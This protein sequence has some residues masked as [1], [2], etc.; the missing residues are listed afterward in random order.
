M[1]RIFPCLLLPG[2]LL[3][4]CGDPKAD[5]GGPPAVEREYVTI[6]EEGLGTIRFFEP[7][8]IGEDL[9][10]KCFSVP[11]T[12]LDSAAGTV[13][14]GSADPFSDPFL[15][16]TQRESGPDAQEVLEN[17]GILFGPDHFARYYPA[18]SALVVVLP[19]EQLELVEAYMCH[20][21]PGPPRPV[22]IYAEVYE[23]EE[24][25]HLH[26]LESVK[27]EADHTPE[28][29][30]LFAAAKLGECSLEEAIILTT[31]S[32]MRAKTEQTESGSKLEVDPVLSADESYLD[33]VLRYWDGNETEGVVI[34][35][36]LVAERQK[37]VS[38]SS[39]KVPEESPSRYRHLMI[40]V[41]APGE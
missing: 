27:G 26:L 3:V 33:L 6:H 8:Q 24:A 10:A 21:G 2:L 41:E 36:T 20:I 14:E 15:P 22:S 35:T 18:D 7:R 5:G 40:K 30:A 11:P 16:G 9:W 32:G 39:W 13:G 23:V 28:R 19:I 25:L 17:A 12:F 1:V 31:Q 38:V 34:D 37:Y 29:D 4:S